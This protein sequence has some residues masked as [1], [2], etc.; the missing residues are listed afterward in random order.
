MSKLRQL[1]ES[2]GIKRSFVAEKLKISPDNFSAKERGTSALSL[3]QI[4][5]LAS[6]YMI[7]FSEMAEIALK[8]YKREVI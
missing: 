1:R 5:V 2:Q 6:V 7:P 4:E 8:T 3:L